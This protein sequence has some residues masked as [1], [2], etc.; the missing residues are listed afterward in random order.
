MDARFQ[1]Q[2]GA[3]DSVSLAAAAMKFMDLAHRLVTGAL[4]VFT[5]G[6]AGA[7]Y[8]GYASWSA[9]MG[10]LRAE[11]AARNAA[12]AAAAEAP[13]AEGASKLA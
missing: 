13:A 1:T 11:L 6:G 4:M 5:I 3:G 7:L 10:V 2:V 9:H 8:T 12:A